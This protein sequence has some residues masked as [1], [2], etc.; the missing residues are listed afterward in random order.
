MKT[1]TINPSNGLTAQVSADGKHL[2]I[3][4]PLIPQNEV[5][6][7]QNEKNYVIAQSGTWPKCWASVD[8]EGETVGLN[9]CALVKNPA[10]PDNQPKPVAPAPVVPAFFKG[11][12][13]KPAANGKSGRIM[14]ASVA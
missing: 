11:K 6:L 9:V 5:K 14:P 8:V 4:V 1:N 12:A 7:T 2:I 3:S 10:H 13:G